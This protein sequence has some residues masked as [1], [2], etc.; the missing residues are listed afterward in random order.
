METP[1][2][3]LEKKEERIII[4]AK[5]WVDPECF[6]FNNLTLTENIITAKDNAWVFGKK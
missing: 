3:Y 2:K 6:H 5:N 4:E 1:V